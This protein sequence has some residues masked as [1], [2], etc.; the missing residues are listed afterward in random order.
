MSRIRRISEEEMDLHKVVIM[1]SEQIADLKMK[2]V[3]LEEKIKNLESK[4]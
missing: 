1:F 2:I 3:E 4:A